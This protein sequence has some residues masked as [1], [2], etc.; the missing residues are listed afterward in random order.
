M[1]QHFARMGIPN[2]FKS[3]GRRSNAGVQLRLMPID[4]SD[5]RV[6]LEKPA[7]AD[8]TIWTKTEER[9]GEDTMKLVSRFEAA[10]RST[11]E[12]H[13]VSAEAF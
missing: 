2:R 8:E 4:D 1:N 5:F 3:L 9:F 7:R 11:A 12:L 10:S 13:G 6:T